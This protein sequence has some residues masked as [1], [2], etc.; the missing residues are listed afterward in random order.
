MNLRALVRIQKSSTG[1]GSQV[2]MVLGC[3][4][5]PRNRI[6]PGVDSPETGPED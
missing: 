1:Y 3:L 2:K 6:S 4:A 5:G